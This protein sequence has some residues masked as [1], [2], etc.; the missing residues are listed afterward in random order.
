[1]TARDDGAHIVVLTTFAD[2]DSARDFVR[3]LVDERIVACGTVLTGATSIYRWE[4]AI[5]EA[6]EALVVLKTTRARWPDLA[7][8]AD[9]WHPYD[10]PELLALPV[11]TGLPAYLAWLDD[12]T[13]VP[14]DPA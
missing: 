5:T 1:M 12:G 13:R 10:V 14:E 11:E 2:G 3:R 8:A 4:G 9:Q 6:E 7:A